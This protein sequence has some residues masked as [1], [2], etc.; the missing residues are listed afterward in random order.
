MEN[1]FHGDSREFLVKVTP[2]KTFRPWEPGGFTRD[3]TPW[4]DLEG[5]L[6][7]HY[8]IKTVVA[9]Y[10]SPHL[11]SAMTPRDLT[12]LRNKDVL[13]STFHGIDVLKSDAEVQEDNN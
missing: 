7:R 1:T 13:I 3:P 4:K 2:K 9:V 6:I 5:F 8:D 10:L 12:A 11:I